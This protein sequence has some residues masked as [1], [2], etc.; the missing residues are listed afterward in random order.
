MNMKNKSFLI[1]CFLFILLL[2]LAAGALDSIKRGSGFLLF[3]SHTPSATMTATPSHTP[4]ET[5]TMTATMTATETSTPTST[6]TVTPSLTFTPTIT[7]TDTAVPTSTVTEVPT[8]DITALAEEI[9]AEVTAAVNAFYYSLT[10]SPTPIMADDELYAGL[11]MI[12]PV[13][14]N[15]LVFISIE[16]DPGKHGFWMDWNEISNAE[17][18][19]C[20]ESGYCSELKSDTLSGKEYYKNV[21]YEDYA[22]VN[23]TR[24]QAFAYCSWAGMQLMAL[25]DWN[26]ASA[27]LEINDANI[28]GICDLP[29]VNS[30]ES[31]NIIGNV[32][33]WTSN[34]DNSGF[35]VIAGGSW[36]T[37]V[38]DIRENRIAKMPLNSYAEDIG[39][40]CVSYVYMNQ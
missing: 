14:N 39:F 7:A 6:Y 23:I 33:E 4:T 16:D 28:D 20:V 12:N 31:S 11:R 18:R 37:A 29:V 1:I 15:E 17:Y 38:Q 25:E 22:V 35:A 34:E 30:T 9:Y 5:S 3:P 24:G 8:Y 32:W 27:V 21:E 2:V 10:P 36:K 26:K 13:D 40:R 19:T